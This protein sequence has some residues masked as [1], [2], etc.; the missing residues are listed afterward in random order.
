MAPGPTRV[1]PPTRIL[2]KSAR[3]TTTMTT[4]TLGGERGIVAIIRGRT[5]E[6]TAPSN[7]GT[8][9]RPSLPWGIPWRRIANESLRPPRTASLGG[10]DRDA[11]DSATT[12]KLAR[13]ARLLRS[14]HD[15]P[16]DVAAVNKNGNCLFRVV[17]LQVYS[18]ALAHTKVRR[19]CLNYKEAV[20]EHY[21]N[22]VVGS[23][24]PPPKTTTTIMRD[25]TR[26]QR[27]ARQQWRGV[28]QRWGA[29][30]PVNQLGKNK[31]TVQ[32]G[33]EKSTGV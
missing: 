5:I 8:S 11:G 4:I 20:A 24:P 21:H 16:L 28:R 14:K 15:P 29:N 19:R 9:S 2:P 32:R 17:S 30:L 18:N 1:P 26:G 6:A 3:T 27:G 10:H 31:T 7:G 13:F 12:N 25:T 33:R 22:F 23:A